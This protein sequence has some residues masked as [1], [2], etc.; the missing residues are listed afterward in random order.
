VF[1]LHLESS[2]PEKYSFF[3]VDDTIK[4]EIIDNPP[5]YL[6]Y[7]RH[8]IGSNYTF[9]LKF[10]INDV[11]FNTS[12]TEWLPVIFSYGFIYPITIENDETTNFFEYYSGFIDDFQYYYMDQG[13]SWKLSEDYFETKVKQSANDFLYDIYYFRRYNIHTGIISKFIGEFD[14][15]YG[16]SYEI[17]IVNPADEGTATAIIIPIV[18]L[19]VIGMIYQKKRRKIHKS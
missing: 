1:I 10:Y 13:Y 15:T 16:F 7:W 4:V 3:K 17:E 14:D 18:S 2:S 11:Y 8:I 5:S 6:D 12:E 9:W 19:V